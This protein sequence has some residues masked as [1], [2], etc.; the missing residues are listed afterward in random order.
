MKKYRLNDNLLFILGCR[1]KVHKDH[2]EKK[3]EI[4]PPC[5]VSLDL[6]TAKEMLLLAPT[7]EEQ[8][9]SSFF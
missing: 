7:I 5:K 1:V 8:Q 3:E 9:V 4:I 6:N 2:L